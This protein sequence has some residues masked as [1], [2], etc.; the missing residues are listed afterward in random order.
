MTPKLVIFDCDGVLVD[1][2][3]PSS[4]AI[5]AFFTDLGAPV[6]AE[7]CRRLFHGKP[8]ELICAE[9][10]ERAGVPADPALPAQ[11][12]A[13]VEETLSEL[14]APIPGVADLLELLAARGTPVCVGSSGSVRKMRMTLGNADL[15]KYFGDRLFSGQDEKR[16]KP[17]PDVF[18]AAA[19]A[20]GIRCEDAVIIE[21]STVGVRAAVASGARVLG[22]VGDPHADAAAVEALGA[23]PFSDM[24]LVPQM[25]GLQTL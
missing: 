24:G 4:E 7:E 3:G 8:M 11:V 14:S 18:L 17:H 20:V 23:E 15:L 10:A 13:A 2:E 16:S 9:M 25:L 19:A 6:S 5:A 21:D 22:Y 1:T 12:R